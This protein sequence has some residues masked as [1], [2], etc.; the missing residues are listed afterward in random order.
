MHKFAPE[1]ETG[2]LARKLRSQQVN[3]MNRRRILRGRQM[4]WIMADE[5][6]VDKATI[7][8]TGITDLVAMEWTEGD[9][10]RFMDNWDS[11]VSSMSAT[12]S[13][14]DEQLE[15]FFVQKGAIVKARRYQSGGPGV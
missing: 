3:A 11:I 7:R 12:E 4:L 2:S 13:L 1:S 8:C 6:R 5:Y 14:N 9:P 10:A 15:L